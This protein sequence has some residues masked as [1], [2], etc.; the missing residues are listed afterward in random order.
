MHQILAPGGV[1][2]N[3]GN[4]S[5]WLTWI[6]RIYNII[7][8]LLWHFENNSTNDPSIELDLEEVKSLAQKIGF[9]ISVSIFSRCSRVIVPE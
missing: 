2:I 8:P 6:A 7:G 1:W 5:F 3:L 9:E 4:Y